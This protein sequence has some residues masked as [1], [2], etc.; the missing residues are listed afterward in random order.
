MGT[1]HDDSCLMTIYQNSLGKPSPW[2]LHSGFYWSK[3]DGGSG[4][5][6]SFNTSKAAVK[7]SPPTNSVRAL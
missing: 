3:D 4:D 2:C 1:Q 6:W 7:L 5:R